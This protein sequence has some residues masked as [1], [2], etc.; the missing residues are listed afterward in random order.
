MG[1][2]DIP[3]GV[4]NLGLSCNYWT[5]PMSSISLSSNAMNGSDMPVTSKASPAADT[6]VNFQA[7]FI[8]RGRLTRKQQRE[9]VLSKRFFQVNVHRSESNSQFV[10]G[11]G[12]KRRVLLSTNRHEAFQ[13]SRFDIHST[14]TKIKSLPPWVF[15]TLPGQLQGAALTRIRSTYSP[16]QSNRFFKTTVKLKTCSN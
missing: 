16:S 1:A 9:H 6:V 5:Q 15:Q 10:R 13:G 7:L 3:V 14:N 12:R 2:L 11:T 4:N 8:I